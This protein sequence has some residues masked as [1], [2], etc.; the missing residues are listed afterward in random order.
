MSG[1]VGRRGAG[2]WGA[3]EGK[4]SGKVLGVEGTRGGS[5]MVEP[6]QCGECRYGKNKVFYTNTL[7]LREV[8]VTPLKPASLS[9]PSAAG[10]GTPPDFIGTGQRGGP[11]ESPG[12]VSSPGHTAPC[13]F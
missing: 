3:A 9:Y 7:G 13:C 11:Q 8:G 4:D 6:V 1:L 10:L 5:L 2:P 12:P